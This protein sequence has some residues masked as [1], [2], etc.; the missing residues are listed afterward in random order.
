MDPD[1]RLVTLT[2]PGGVG[3][4]RLAIEAA[5]RWASDRRSRVTFVALA[6][7]R[8]PALVNDTIA[9]ALELQVLSG[10]PLPDLISAA[11]HGA[12]TLLVLDNMEHVL[13][14]APL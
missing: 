9:L 6:A 1:V 10:R 13:P 11:L 5:T 7:L 3:K 4:T 14:A 2:G 12:P 8:D